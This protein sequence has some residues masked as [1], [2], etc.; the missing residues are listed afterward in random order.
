MTNQP[1]TTQSMTT[2]PARRAEPMPAAERTLWPVLLALLGAVALAIGWVGFI[3]SDDSLY[4]AGAMRWLTDG[5][6]PG[7]D[8]WSTRFPLILSF[9]AALR[10]LGEGF[11]AFA[12]TAVAWHVALV[13][14]A[15]A[16]AARIGGARAGWIAAI[17]IAT[18][19]VIVSHAS[20]VSCDLAEA[21][22]L[23]AGAWLL[24]AEG[25]GRDALTRA[26][27]GGLCFGLAILCRETALLALVAFGP[28][29]LLG[30][31]IDRRLLLAAGIGIALVLGLEML[32][33][34]AMTGDP[35]HRY[36]LAFNHDDHIDRAANLEGNVLLHPAIDPLLVLLVNDDF[37]LLF[38]LAA[39]ALGCGALRGLPA[40]GRRRLAVLGAMALANFL[41][42]AVLY[43]KLVLNPRYF[44]LPAIVAAFVLAVWL[45]RLP[46][47]PR[48]ALLALT[49]A[50]N[51]LMLSVGNAHPRWA[52]EATVA[53][54]AAN[55]HAIVRADPDVVARAYLPLRFGGIA[56]VRPAPATP[57]D[58]LVTEQPPVD[59]TFPV[60][61]YPAP[62]T[63]LGALVEALGMQSLVPSPIA[64][65]LL[66]PSPDAFLVRVPPGPRAPA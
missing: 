44:T 46:R 65:R 36:A 55:R 39:A 17:L 6:S 64:R 40:E 26:L 50:T 31:P 32:F 66:H 16:L 54:G 28:L 59:P 29:F 62:P 3:A 42:V 5:P 7:L 63:R 57:G 60:A 43:H 38:W 61:R 23:L 53:A 22:F 41:I 33:Q 37:A 11:A 21:C 18:M 9:A 19:P 45:A 1:T 15:G 12:A 8:H 30:R 24:C 25:G 35:L 58:L 48:A 51:L 13:A 34:Q 52:L 2:Q 56:N 4:F 49:V 20:T 14:L 47:L 10:L 27:A